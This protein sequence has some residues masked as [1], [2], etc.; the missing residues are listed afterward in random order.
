[1]AANPRPVD[2]QGR[3]EV[4]DMRLLLLAMALA[5]F[6]GCPR[7][8][9]PPQPPPPGA[10]AGAADC[11]TACAHL[12]H[13]GCVAARPTSRGNTC[14]EVCENVRSSGFIEWDVACIARADTCDATEGC[15]R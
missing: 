1:M 8:L 9:P 15:T 5:A 10:D 4:A 6:T 2:S 12:A 3:P 13:L 7:P 14:T 11:R